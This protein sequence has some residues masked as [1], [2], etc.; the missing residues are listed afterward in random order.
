MMSFTPK[1]PTGEA[2]V[3]SAKREPL[4][5]VLLLDNYDSFTYNIVQLLLQIGLKPQVIQSDKLTLPELEALTF[6]HL[7]LSP[8]PGR[9]ENAGI[10]LA[11]IQTLAPRGVPILG[12]CLGHQALALAFGGS[13]KFADTI[14]HGTISNIENNGKGLFTNLPSQFNVTRYHSL[15]VDNNLPDT[16]EVTAWHTCPNKGDREIM[17]LQHRF[18]PCFGVQFHPE[19]ILSEYGHELLSHFCGPQRVRPMIK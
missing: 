18:L 11:A 8:G 13:I 7:I 6:S 3:G 17:G 16:L 14:C 9:P 15:I 4:A 5:Q 12:I 1:S 19:A 2:R 10:T